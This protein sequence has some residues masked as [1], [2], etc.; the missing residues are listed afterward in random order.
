MVD[1][2][3][4]Q[5]T[6]RRGEQGAFTFVT[7]VTMLGFPILERGPAFGQVEDPLARVVPRL[8]AVVR[9][10]GVERDAL[11]LMKA[12]HDA[13]IFVAVPTPGGPLD[14]GGRKR[15]GV[16]QEPVEAL[17]IAA[18]AVTLSVGHIAPQCRPAGRRTSTSCSGRG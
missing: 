4:R 14:T 6:K 10:Q 18:V 17:L 2:V 11:R 3:A 9:L 1:L 13:R 12:L 5:D 15:A 8:H 7:D 16:T